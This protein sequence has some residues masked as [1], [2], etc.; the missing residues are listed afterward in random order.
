MRT[1]LQD[2]RQRLRTIERHE[3]FRRPMDR[4]QSLR[5]LLDERQRALATALSQRIHHGER[6]VQELSSR[7]DRYMPAAVNRLRERVAALRGS[8]SA[9]MIWR[10]RRASEQIAGAATVLANNHPRH[11]VQL[12]RLRLTALADRLHRSAQADLARRVI[13][14]EA[15]GRQLHAISPENVLRRGYSMTFR[16]KDRRLLRTAGDVRA[17]DILLTQFADGQ[18]ESVARDLQQP[19]LFE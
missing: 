17:N 5:Q 14:V 9:G 16:K 3:A 2:A 6:D 15:M 10:I 18:V 1:L 8:L 4:I 19:E 13:Q 12:Q 7:L 11:P